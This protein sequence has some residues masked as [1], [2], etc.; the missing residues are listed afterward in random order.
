MLKIKQG[1]KKT[2]P[3][4]VPRILLNM[5]AGHISMRHSLRGPNHCLTTACATGA[6]SIGDAFTAIRLGRADLMLAGGTEACV[7]PLALAGFARLRSLSTSHN[8]DPASSCRPFDAARDGFVM[9]EGAAA[10]VLED[11]EHAR[12][13]GA[14]VYAEVK[15]WGAAG[16]AHHMTAPRADGDGALRAMRAALREAGVSAD[17][18]DYINAHATGTKVGDGAEILAIGELMKDVRREVAVSATKGATGHLLGA[19]GAVEAI[20]TI[21]AIHEVGEVGPDAVSC[22]N[23][24]Q[25]MM[26]PT[27]NLE[28]PDVDGAGLNLVPLKAQKKDKLDVALSNS[29]GF[30]GANSSLVFSRLE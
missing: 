10:L 27:L 21:L 11:L 15:G 12:K 23:E 28:S 22:A 26:P 9:A 3:L 14:R 2:P 19:S 16:D 18:V 30:G 7:H 4:F 29:F 20:F 24:M 25:R 13:R 6:D 8:D 1:Y 5:A 17:K